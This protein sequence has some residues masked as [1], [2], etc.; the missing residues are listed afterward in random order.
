[1]KHSSKEK[2]TKSCAQV[3]LKRCFLMWNNSLFQHTRNGNYICISPTSTFCDSAVNDSDISVAICKELN[4]SISPDFRRLKK[5]WENQVMLI[6]QIT[7]HQSVSPPL[8]SGSRYRQVCDVFY[9]NW[10]NMTNLKRIEAN[11][12]SPSSAVASSVGVTWLAVLVL[13]FNSPI[14]DAL[15]CRR[16]TF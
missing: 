13:L 11:H 15:R 12:F 16:S 2:P 5:A 6:H 8:L 1:M 14:L 4:V 9:Q 10:A 3:S 7:S